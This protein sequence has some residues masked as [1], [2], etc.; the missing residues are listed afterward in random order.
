MNILGASGNSNTVQ[1][2]GANAWN[3]AQRSL[4]KQD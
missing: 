4:V 2:P 3:Q 1:T